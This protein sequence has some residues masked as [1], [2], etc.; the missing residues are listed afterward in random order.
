MN[1]DQALLDEA[2]WLAQTLRTSKDTAPE[3]IQ[4]RLSMYRPRF[5]IQGRVPQSHYQC[6]RCWMRTSTQ[7]ALRSAHGG[8]DHDLL[9]CNDDRCGAEFVIPF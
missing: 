2:R 6:P 7:S 9:R 1:P 5:T 8:D 4:G 3:I